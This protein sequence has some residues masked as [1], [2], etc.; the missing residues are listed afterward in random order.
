MSSATD[1]LPSNGDEQL[2]E[3]APAMPTRPKRTTAGKPPVRYG[4]PDSW[5][6]EVCIDTMVFYNSNRKQKNKTVREAFVF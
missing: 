3:P 2:A 5:A 1:T 6:T 4:G